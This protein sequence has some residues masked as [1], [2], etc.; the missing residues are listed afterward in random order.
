[1]DIVLINWSIWL[2]MIYLT[3]CQMGHLVKLD[4]QQNIP[5]QDRQWDFS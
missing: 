3:I 4:K 5:C 1:M 2:M